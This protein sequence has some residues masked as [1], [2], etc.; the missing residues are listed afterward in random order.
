MT[1]IPFVEPLIPGGARLA[2]VVV[3]ESVVVVPGERHQ[4]DPKPLYNSTKS[5]LEQQDHLSIGS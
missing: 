3:G 2:G 4:L 5:A 1:A